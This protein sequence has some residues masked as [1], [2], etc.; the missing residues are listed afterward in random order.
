M[1]TN[2]FA[3]TAIERWRL[4]VPFHERSA[5]TVDI[6][7]PGWSVVDLYRVTLASG[8]MGVG[9][10]LENYTWGKIADD[11]A[12]THIGANAFDLMWDDGLGAGLQMAIFDAVGQTAGVPIHRLLGKQYREECPVSW[13][14]QD[15]APKLWAAEA[16]AAEKHGFT[17]MK[18]KARPWFDIEDQ[19]EAVSEATSNHFQLD[20]DFN[21]LLLGVDQ[22]APLLRRLEETFPVLAIYESPI[23]Q[24]DVAGNAA[25]RRKVANPIAMHFGSPPVMT[26]IREGVCDGFVIGGGATRVMRDGT[27]ADYAKMPFWLQ[28][29]GT[30]L[31]TTFAAHLGAVLAQ[32]RW[33]A[34]PCINIYSH[35]LLKEFAVTGGHVRVPDAPGLGVEVDWEAVERFRVEPDYRKPQPREIHTIYW[36]DGR[37]TH[38]KNGGYREEF[39][40]GRLPGF[41]P[42]VRLERALDDGSDD[43]DREY[44]KLFG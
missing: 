15:M 39:L 37:Q 33:P 23:P 24:D 28:M 44:G 22:A 9:E 26:A 34:I 13:W 12:Q 38:Y 2:D 41:L 27:L 43:F 14:A 10:T 16:A 32:A 3:I 1:S 31:T 36:P 7:V 8:A 18:V 29:V 19:L 4:D 25:L 6:R 20:A 35:T 30:G 5:H 17:T 21:G 11:G 40:A 42:G